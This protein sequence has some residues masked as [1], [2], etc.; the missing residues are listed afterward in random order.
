MKLTLLKEFK[1]KAKK[2]FRYSISDVATDELLNRHENFMMALAEVMEDEDTRSRFIG[3]YK[4]K[5]DAWLSARC[6]CVDNVQNPE[7]EPE[8][9][10]DF[11]KTRSLLLVVTST[12][13]DLNCFRRI[14]IIKAERCVRKQPK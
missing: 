9:K 1:K 3:E 6:R 14:S 4:E 13:D 8:L 5:L 11:A 2:A 12:L 10:L 7:P